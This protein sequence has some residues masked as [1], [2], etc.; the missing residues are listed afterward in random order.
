MGE[1]SRWGK[2]PQSADQEPVR[3]FPG[4][5]PLDWVQLWFLVAVIAVCLSYLGWILWPLA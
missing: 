5:E 4:M 3:R 1:H 2:R